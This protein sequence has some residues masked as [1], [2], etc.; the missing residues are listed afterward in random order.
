[1][2][3]TD[4]T[5]IAEYRLC[6]AIY[7]QPELI[8]DPQF[9]YDLLVHETPKD[10][11]KSIDEMTR[12]GIPLNELSIFNKLS[13]LNINAT[14]EEVHTI[15]SLNDQPLS[16][17]KDT[18][19]YLKSGKKKVESIL[20]LEELKSL[21][22]SDTVLNEAQREK[23]R[24]EFDSAE[25]SIFSLEDGSIKRVLSLKEWGEMWNDEFVK[26][27]NGKR[28]FFNDPHLDEIVADGPFPGT[29]GLFVAASGM[30]KTA[31][32]T[33]LFNGFINAGIPTGFF[34]LEMGAIMTYDR[35]MSDR[36]QIPYSEI[37][38]PEDEQTYESVRVRLEQEKQE[39]DKNANVFFCEDAGVGLMDIERAIIKFQEKI[40]QKYCVVFLDLIT[41][42]KEFSKSAQNM[43]QAIEI[44]INLTSAMAKRLGCH[45]IGTAQIGR[46]V[47]EGRCSDPEDVEHFRPMVNDI[48]NSNALLER[49]RYV[50]SLFRKK[51]YLEKYFGDDQELLD[52]TNDV[53]EINTLKQ[54]NGK[55]AR[56]YYSFYGPTFSVTPLL[57]T[58]KQFEDD[59]D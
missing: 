5:I 19:D 56:R 40:G 26:R 52:S 31:F 53:I 16:T 29:V 54:N 3:K 13:T 34:S 36:T 38:N 4:S 22:S 46:G 23:L 45:I 49:C 10:F 59:D 39:L 18:V 42:V 41:M 7:L 6:N 37:T 44:A 1:M 32:V 2:P 55:L 28:F 21:L 11:I 33:H 14:M 47:E 17:I 9:S 25:H 20:H 48:K 50:I 51:Y 58:E 57:D 30:G 12:S 27:R 35:W 8:D 24:Q 15:I 43:A